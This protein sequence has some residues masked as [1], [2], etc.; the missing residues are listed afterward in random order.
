MRTIARLLGLTLLA[1]LPLLGCER[2]AN[3]PAAQVQPVLLRYDV[4]GMHCEGCV[5]AIETKV[6]RIKGVA[7]CE[8]S[9]DDHEAIVTIAEADRPD[10]VREAVE[11]TIRG[12][13]YTIAPKP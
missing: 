5:A 1:G 7:A 4:Q 12:L 10:E 9:L 11:S 6:G 8:V 13:H 2:P 3:V